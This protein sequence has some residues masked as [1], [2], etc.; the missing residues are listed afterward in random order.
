M[1]EFCLREENIM[2]DDFEITDSTTR[3]QLIARVNDLDEEVQ[4]LE[5]K[6]ED[7]EQEIE[8]LQLTHT[9]RARL[10]D[11]ADEWAAWGRVHNTPAAKR[12]WIDGA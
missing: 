11:A 12:Q 2:F 8:N 5:T 9:Q 4:T 7:Q 6:V 3:E 1:A 10:Q